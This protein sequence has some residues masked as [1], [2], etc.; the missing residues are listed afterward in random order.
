MSATA[1]FLAT[2]EKLTNGLQFCIS[3]VTFILYDIKVIHTRCVVIK[4]LTKLRVSAMCKMCIFF[5]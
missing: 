5:L 4:C 2:Y 3:Y 1:S